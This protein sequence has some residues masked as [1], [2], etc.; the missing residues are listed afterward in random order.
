MRGMPIATQN[1]LPADDEGYISVVQ[2]DGNTQTIA[3]FGKDPV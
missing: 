3:S 1:S 2:A